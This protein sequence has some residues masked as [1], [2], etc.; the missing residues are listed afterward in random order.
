MLGRLGS[1]HRLERIVLVVALAPVM[2]LSACEL[3]DDS[4]EL[5]D[6]GLKSLSRRDYHAAESFFNRSLESLGRKIHGKAPDDPAADESIVRQICVVYANMA[7]MH[8]AQGSYSA[9][10]DWY[11]KALALYETRVGTIDQ[12]IAGLLHALSNCYF[13]MGN[14]EKAAQMS[15]R[16]LLF[17][18]HLGAQDIR[19]AVVFNN[20]AQIYEKLDQKEDAE[21]YF[22]WAMNLSDL[23]QKDSLP[24]QIDILNNYAIFCRRQKK[25]A[26]AK[27]LVERAITLQKH[28]SPGFSEAKVKSLYVLAGIERE[29]YD[30][31]A[32]ELHYAE[33][34]ELIH[35]HPGGSPALECEGLD[36]YA[37]LLLYERRFSE[38]EPVF[39]HCLEHCRSV[40]G[41]RHPCIAERLSDMS[42]LYR[43]TGRNREAESALRQALDIYEEAVGP[44]SSKTMETLNKLAAVLSSEGKFRE[45]DALY[46]EMVPKLRAALGNNHPYLA[47]ALDNWAMFIDKVRGQEAAT[48]LRAEARIIRG[49]PKAVPRPAAPIPEIFPA[50]RRTLG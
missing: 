47:D 10:A 7:K 48:K 49:N 50:G 11:Q 9:A 27:Q 21:V 18:K 5:N 38:A 36:A 17:Y 20:L 6:Q 28:E 34:L 44:A 29:T 13:N 35:E 32:A 26:Q 30:L 2:M 12:F 31:E 14:Y 43:R 23:K 4:D 22:Q 41:P 39:E 40:H 25:F 15:H 37:N 1:G 24:A 19:V 42:L 45:A 33:A 46:R 8:A 3:L 16:E